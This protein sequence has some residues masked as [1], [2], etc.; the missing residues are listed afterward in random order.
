VYLDEVVEGEPAEQQVGEELK[1][2]ENGKNNP[3]CEPLG[4]VLFGAGLQGLH[5]VEGWVEEANHVA[6]QLSSIAE[7]Q[8]QCE[9]S[10]HPCGRL[11]TG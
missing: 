4:V 8:V 1:N 6:Q 9:E 2:G 11:K 5:G 7:K 10:D 3:V